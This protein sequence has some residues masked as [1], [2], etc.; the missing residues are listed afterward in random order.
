MAENVEILLTAAI[1]AIGFRIFF[2]QTFSIPTNSM[3]P[4]YY[5]M[6][7][8]LED[9]RD[10]SWEDIFLR[11]ITYHAISCRNGGRVYIPINNRQRAVQQQSFVS[12]K[13]V[14]KRLFFL[15]PRYFRRY[16]LLVGNENVSVDVPL[17]FDLES[18]L[19]EQFFPHLHSRRISDAFA[20]I[21]PKEKDGQLLLPTSVELRPG[22]NVL[23][24]RLQR[25]DI[26]LVNR[27]SLHFFPP[28][29]GE[30]IVFATNRVPALRGDDRYYIK[31]IVGQWGDYISIL[32]GQLWRNGSPSDDAHAICMNNEHIFP[33]G[34]YFPLGNLADGEFLI[35]KGT[36][37]VL[38]DNSENSY[39]SR[40]FGPI[41]RDAIIGRPSK[42]LFPSR[43]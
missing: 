18:T 5:G 22:E 9:K 38:G 4:T 39:D 15:F 20:H 16:T 43:R 25:G 40:F 42:V 7:A 26:L 2:Y 34:G 23:S 8:I 30:P 28:Q 33:Y 35:P 37:F 11:G 10:N 21:I 32:D 24:F 41:P 17:E 36:V 6:T 31:R 3:I 13:V 12:Y 14:S 29:R 1:I 19:V 27:F